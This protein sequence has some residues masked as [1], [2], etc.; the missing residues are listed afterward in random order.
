MKPIE[1]AAR[2]A[3]SVLFFFLGTKIGDIR[4]KAERSS[5]CPDVTALAVAPQ[6][7]NNV[8]PAEDCTEVAPVVEMVRPKVECQHAYNHRKNLSVLHLGK[9]TV[10]EDVF[11]FLHH[12]SSPAK[13][14]YFLSHTGDWKADTINE[15]PCQEVYLTR[16]GSRAS[17]PNKCVA[18]TVIPEGG[19]SMVQQSHRVGFTALNTDQYQKDFPQDYSNA[20]NNENLLLLPLL[21]SLH[22]LKAEFLKKMG[23][24][25]DPV[26]GKRRVAIVMVANEGV[27]DLLL[28][29][30]CSAEG[31]GVDIGSVVVFVGDN[32]F[33][34]VIENIGAK[35]VYHPDL[36]SMPAHA[37]KG[38]LDDTFS[39]MM[40]FK[41]TSVYLALSAGF[42][43]M[44]Q[45]VDLVWLKDPFP[46]FAE[47]SEDILFMDDGARTPRYTPF[48]VNSGFYFVKYNERTLY[49]FEKMMKCG[50]SE[51][52]QTHSHQSVL[53]RH[54]AESHH[55]F[56]LK[57][58]VLDTKLF[59]SGQTYHENKNQVK[60]IIARTFRPYVFHMCW[61]SNR[62]DKV[63]Y[64]KEM[65]LWYLPDNR[66]VCNAGKEMLH[67][68]LT[69]GHTSTASIRD[70]CCL[71]G[72]YW[73]KEEADAV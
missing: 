8:L 62:V 38:Y 18:V 9:A 32:K 37:A 30:I 67:Y 15:S 19:E 21:K 51:I 56:G 55:L 54:I 68:A 20:H 6:I 35:A 17:Q 52:G 25:I 64:F 4:S 43:V 7:F 16:T 2:V 53:I 23:D 12:P 36:G 31:V 27:M 1:V 59:P 46:Y 60:K 57:V 63:I 13:W 72:K 66:D 33:V 42:E 41:T 22:N 10:P 50:A 26:T 44:F 11:S 73:P 39:R 3:L 29:F 14:S 71:R 49:M 61:T 70:K 65:G 45:D 47:R 58:Y 34:S 69:Y 5:K 28:N 24:P 40:W 48:F